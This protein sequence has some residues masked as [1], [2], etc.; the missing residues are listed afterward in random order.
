[1]VDPVYNLNISYKN[2]DEKTVAEEFV[3]NIFKD[4]LNSS[5]D[6]PLFEEGTL[7]KKSNT[8]KWFKEMINAEYSKSITKH[9]LKPLVNTLVKSFGNN[10]R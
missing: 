3:S 2:Y 7:L 8:E 1:M 5:E 10:I 9:S 6:N 4:I